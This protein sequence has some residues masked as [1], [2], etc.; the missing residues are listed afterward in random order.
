MRG[1]AAN[2][3]ATQANSQQIGKPIQSEL[4]AI[5]ERERKTRHIG[6]MRNCR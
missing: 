5:A 2:D 3:D 4:E 1:T 6:Q